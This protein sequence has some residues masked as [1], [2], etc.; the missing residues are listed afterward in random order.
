LEHSADY[1]DLLSTCDTAA[2]CDCEAALPVKIVTNLE[3]NDSETVGL[4][5]EC[6]CDFWFRLCEET[7]VG[8]VC[9]YAAE[10]CCGDYRYSE[11]DV[12]FWYMYLNSPLCYC[13]F[14]NYAQKEFGHTLKPKAL[15]MSDEFSNPCG[16]FEY[17]WGNEAEPEKLEKESL[18]AIYNATNGEKWTNN[19]G[20]MN[21]TVDHCQWY[22][23]SCDARGFVT[24]IDLRDNSLEGQFPVYTNNVDEW[25]DPILDNDFKRT[26]Y[27]LANLYKL[28]TLDLSNNKLSG[29][30]DH[31]PLYNL[32]S[33]THFDVSGNQLSGEVNALVAPSLTHADFSNNNFA[34][35]RRFHKYKKSFQ[36]LRYCDV[37]NNTIKGN[38]TELLENV[39][40]NMVQFIA[41]NNR[42][43]GNLPDSLNNLQKLRQ[44]NMSSN[45]LS[46]VLPGFTESFATLEELDMSNQTIGFTGSIP[47]DIWR[48]LSLLILNLAGNKLTGSIATLVGTMTVLEEFD[49]SNNH[50][51]SSI[52]S[53]LGMLDGK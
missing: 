36:S 52:P 17:Y 50:L 10:Y 43:Y 24:S 41:S 48:S 13:D 26:K 21:A 51:D 30:I 45:A 12:N 8:A 5:N 29:T 35:M 9:D 19:Y 16:Q 33:L 46:G 34:S 31:A 47:K 49:V 6:R 15:N 25:G 22:G 11:D 20:W 39:P 32:P 37:G 53:E 18:L 44:F 40:P 38:A 7:G 14:F 28:K 42:I 4:Y 3:Y 23:I 27:G 2:S 1:P